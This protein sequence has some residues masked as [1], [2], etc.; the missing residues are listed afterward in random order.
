MSFE[1]LQS[2]MDAIKEA[3]EVKKAEEIDEVRNRVIE[4]AK[5]VG[6]TPLSLFR[7]K[8]GPKYQHPEELNLTWCGRG[9][10]PKWLRE[11]EAEG[12][13]RESMLIEKPDVGTTDQQQA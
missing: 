2:K 11:L 7:K 1:D 4:L 6:E 8:V 3:M 5:S 9:R 13:D 10:E 12:V